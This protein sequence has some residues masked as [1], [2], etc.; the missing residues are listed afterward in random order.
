MATKKKTNEETQ[1]EEIVEETPQ[2]QEEPVA[3]ASEETEAPP[4]EEPP[5]QDP[6]APPVTQT[7]T[8]AIVLEHISKLNEEETSN[9]L[10]EFKSILDTRHTDSTKGALIVDSLFREVARV[11]KFDAEAK[12]SLEEIMHRINKVVGGQGFLDMVALARSTNAN[13]SLSISQKIQVIAQSV[14]QFLNGLG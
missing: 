4:V 2:A 1:S 8:E 6:P 14:D 12:K 5:V 9:L 7:E 3:E 11:G 13:K 10:S